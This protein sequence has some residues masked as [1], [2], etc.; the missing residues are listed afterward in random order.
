M[1]SA[2]RYDRQLRL[3]GDYGQR[4][5][6]KS[7]ICVLGSSAVATELL[8]NLVLPGIGRFTIIDNEIVSEGDLGTNF[9]VTH[10]DLGKSR[11]KV[12]TQ[13]LL[14]MNDQVQ[15][16]GLYQ[17]WS[18][19]LN[20]SPDFFAKFNLVALTQC[21]NSKLTSQLA[22]LCWQLRIPLVITYVAGFL[23][24][25][26]VQ[27]AEHTVTETHTTNT[28]DL[29]L[30]CPFP[31]MKELFS[32]FNLD[33]EDPIE[34]GNIP[35][36]V[37]LYHILE[38]WK[39]N[40]PQKTIL[41]FSDKREIRAMVRQARH[42]SQ[43]ENFQEAEEY[44]V[45][46]LNPTVLP[47]NVLALFDH[48][49]CRSQLTEA[50]NTFWIL[51]RALADFVNKEGQ[52]RLPVSGQVPD[53]KTDTNSYVSIQRVYHEQAERDYQ[54]VRSRVHDWLKQLGRS[55]ADISDDEIRRLC[56]HAAESRLQRGSEWSK[57]LN[58][59]PRSTSNGELGSNLLWYLA[60]HAFYNQ[61]Q[62]TSNSSA[63]EGYIQ[64]WQKEGGTHA[65]PTGLICHL[66]TRLDYLMKHSKSELHNTAAMVGGM[67]AQ[68]IV[69]L[70]THQ[71]LPLLNTCIVNNI[72]ATT[73]SFSW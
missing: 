53:M 60:Y 46:A 7:H 65:G 43:E 41:S 39:R 61:I 62:I 23:G 68:E 24:H 12:T 18:T 49:T 22:A 45:R 67:V 58:R 26:R 70:V 66:Q 73:S 33:C 69:K 8:K 6:Q 27:V 14:E 50:S 36:V 9:F 4:C 21:T 72:E 51:I 11:A 3:W 42:N 30:D 34:H 48:P 63:L 44:V 13:N 47:A 5:L 16:D 37:I 54:C 28:L 71:Y 17:D 19:L 52:G 15:G 57:E 35:F 38:Q 32:K 55:L 10:S 1:D 59:L 25:I 56:K 29:R 20:E 2:Q 40:N 64:P 31:A